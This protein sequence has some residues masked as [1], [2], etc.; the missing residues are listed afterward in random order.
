MTKTLPPGA[1]QSYPDVPKVRVADVPFPNYGASV[2]GASSAI[3]LL[4]GGSVSNLIVPPG[5]FAGFAQQT[6]ATQ[7]MFR[8]AG[9]RGG[10]R[11]AA[12]RRRSK[13]KRATAPRAAKRRAPRRG[14]S[15]LVKGSAAA[16]A[17]MAKIRK[18]RK[19]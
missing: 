19:R 1:P 14:K 6:P 7:A 10:K 9:R 13:K 3:P 18:M 16:K 11:S 5:G 4:T 12:K 17:Y 2:G 8:A 15:R